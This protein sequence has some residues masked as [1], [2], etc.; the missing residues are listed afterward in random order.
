VS[1]KAVPEQIHLTTHWKYDITIIE[2]QSGVARRS[3]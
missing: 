1:S 3:P 2:L